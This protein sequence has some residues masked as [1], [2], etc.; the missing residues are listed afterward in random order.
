[1]AVCRGAPRLSH[2]LFADDNI[3]FCRAS[4]EECDRLIKVL[5]EYDGDSG[6]KLN[7]E[8]TSLFFSKNTPR[9]TREYVQQRFGA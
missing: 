6:Q 5:E 8:K 3:V 9:E 2:L 4:M 7:K 1:M